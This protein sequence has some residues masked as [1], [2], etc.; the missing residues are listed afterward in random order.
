MMSLSKCYFELTT[1][2]AKDQ[3]YNQFW[4]IL[5]NEFKLSKEMMLLIS[6]Y[7]SLME[8]EV[9]TKKS[10]EIREQI[11]LPLLVIQQYALQKVE[12][13][14]IHKNKYEKLVKR[15]MYGNVNASRNSA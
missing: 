11:V 12:L 15:S 9:V 1:Y 13:N 4:N 8:E 14:S 5:L 6:G 7:T 10:I 3:E 2:I